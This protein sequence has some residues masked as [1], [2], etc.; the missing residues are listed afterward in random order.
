MNGGK[1]TQVSQA[2]VNLYA[3]FLYSYCFNGVYCYVILGSDLGWTL[4][5][6]SLPRDGVSTRPVPVVYESKF[7]KYSR[8]MLEFQL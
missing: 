3:H 2:F 4:V 7:F 8:T 6:Y 1:T 5:M